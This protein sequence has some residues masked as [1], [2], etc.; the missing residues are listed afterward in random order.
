MLIPSVV[1]RK[2][3]YEPSHFTLAMIGA[4]AIHTVI[5]FGISFGGFKEPEENKIIPQMEVTLVSTRSDVVPEDVDYLAQANQEGGGN[6]TD[7]ARPE[8]PFAPLIPKEVIEVTT[9]A[10][11]QMMVPKEERA[12]RN[13]LLTQ[14][15][16]KHTVVA[17]L[18]P[19]EKNKVKQ[20]DVAELISM[21][22]T[23][24]SM[25]AEL[26]ESI[27]QYSKKLRSKSITAATKEYKYASYMESWARK[28][29][30]IGKLNFPTGAN[31]KAL[32]GNLIVDI[33]INA[34]GSVRRFKI[35]RTSGIRAL[36]DA[37]LRILKLAAPF[38]PLP[39]NIRSD[40]DVL[41]ITKKWDFLAGNTLNAH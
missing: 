36:D 25:E 38:A 3:H 9:P 10:P 1:Q 41:H 11:P 22:K 31:G 15:R 4:A 5:I 28:V 7:K 21:S 40:T 34:D 32:E 37:A 39:P 17:D 12:T 2:V 19:E 24:A 8:T 33:A 30:K 14:E 20:M 27:K 13:E 23:I 26:G 6:T 18:M 35:M 29:E 16:S